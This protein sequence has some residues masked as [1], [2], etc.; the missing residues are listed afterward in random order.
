MSTSVKE[1]SAVM[2]AFMNNV[3]STGRAATQTHFQEVWNNQT[4][5]NSAHED[6]AYKKVSQLKDKAGA[7]E[8]LKAKGKDLRNNGQEEEVKPDEKDFE[9]VM[10]TLNSAAQDLVQ[11]V[12][13]TFGMS[14]EELRQIMADMNMSTLDVLDPEM[15]SALLL[16]A[17]GAEGPMALLT[18]EE[19]YADFQMLMNAQKEIVTE[20]GDEL[21]FANQFM[22]NAEVEEIMTE[23][24][25]ELVNIEVNVGET[26]Q[27]TEQKEQFEQFAVERGTQNGSEE[28][29]TISRAEDTAQDGKGQD[30]HSDNTDGQTGNLVLDTMKADN[31]KPQ[32]QQATSSQM[33]WDVDTQNIMRQIMD[34]MKINLKSDVSNLEM[35]LHPASLGTLQVQ[36]ASKGGVIT[37]NFITQNEAVKATLE[38]QMVQLQESF[39]EQGV[40]VEAIEVTVQ[41]HEFERNLDQGRGRQ[42][43]EPEKKNRTRRINLNASVEMDETEDLT[44]EEQLATEMMVANGT[45][46][47]YTV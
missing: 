38:S 21:A 33:A 17:G 11:Q 35:Q 4:G 37:A 39:A 24:S 19:L 26:Q 32:V 44:Q 7:G 34:Y 42:S 47:D 10:E 31:L 40:K 27:S 18:N 41:T 46:V 3:S 1:V 12:A 22:G 16:K 20:L 15:L 28:M 6:E 43:G 2:S 8:E 13:D 30:K 9:V 36:V 14:M 45:T 5:K 29:K 25:E 23:T